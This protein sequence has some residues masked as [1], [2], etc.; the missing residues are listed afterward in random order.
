MKKNVLKILSLFIAILMVLSLAACGE[1]TTDDTDKGDKDNTSKDSGKSGTIYGTWI[2]TEIDFAKIEGSGSGEDGEG[3]GLSLE[4]MGL[5]DLK[6]KMIYTFNEDGTYAQTFDDASLDVITEKMADFSVKMM[7]AFAEAM[8][9]SLEELLTSMGQTLDEYKASVSNKDD[10]KSN[11]KFKI[12]GNKL[13][14]LEDLKADETEDG[15][16]EVA[17][18]RTFDENV[19]FEFELSGNTLTFTNCVDPEDPAPEGLFPIVFTRK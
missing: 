12:D 19:Y 13:F 10:Y 9:S 16:E 1:S 4:D 3:A 15:G 11:G 18:E 17:A 7:E 6:V 2:S 8:G 14:T 5:A